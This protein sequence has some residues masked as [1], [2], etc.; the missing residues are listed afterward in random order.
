[1]ISHKPFGGLLKQ[2]F[3][4]SSVNMAGRPAKASVQ[5]YPDVKRTVFYARLITG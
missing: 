2:T 5:Q 4:F 1:M 3:S